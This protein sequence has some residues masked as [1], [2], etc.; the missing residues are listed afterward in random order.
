[1][2]KEVRAA[3]TSH[4]YIDLTFPI[5]ACPSLLT[6]TRNHRKFHQHFT[7]L[8]FI[9]R[10]VNVAKVFLGFRVGVNGLF[11]NTDMLLVLEFFLQSDFC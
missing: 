1:M 5:S 4:L 7:Y 10:F 3:N 8:S 2:H 9:N 11:H 6:G